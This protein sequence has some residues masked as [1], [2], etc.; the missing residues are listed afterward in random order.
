MGISILSFPMTWLHL[1]D[2]VASLGELP[3]LSPAV[4]LLSPTFC[5][6][7]AVEP[8][9]CLVQY[10]LS[11]QFARCGQDTLVAVYNFYALPGQFGLFFF[12]TVPICHALDI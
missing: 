12:H 7:S 5:L 4:R 6:Q 3:V 2:N 9:A 10:P 11:H 1:I 8:L